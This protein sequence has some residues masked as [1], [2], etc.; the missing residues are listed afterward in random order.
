MDVAKSPHDLLALTADLTLGDGLQ[1]MLAG[2]LGALHGHASAATAPRAEAV[3]R[4]RVGI[5]RLRS[6]LSAFGDALPERERRALSDR[7]RAVA[8]RYGRAREWDVFLG[9]TVAPL[10]AAMPD[11]DALAKLERRAIKARR[12]A[13]PPGDTLKLGLE[14]IEAAMADAAGWLH[15]PTPTRIEMWKM[16]LRDYAKEL[17]AKRHRRLRR[18]LK[19]ADLTDQ[20]AFHQLRIR[21]KKIRYPSELLKT[22]FEKENTS[23]YLARLVKLQDLM[24]GLNDALVGR[25][26]LEELQGPPAARHI[27]GGWIAHEIAECRSRFPSTART[28]RRG[29][30]FWES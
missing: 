9:Q 30:G 23:E 22:L 10:R 2:A 16:P 20:A 19:H 1:E 26:L 17:L 15:T 11:E 6:I 3:H 24:G 5:R 25:Q 27:V 28:F 29:S 4:F 7:L 12:A 21:V 8:Q 18:G 14:T 13:L